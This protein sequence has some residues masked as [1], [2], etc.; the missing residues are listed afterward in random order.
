MCF[1]FPIP[2]LWRMCSAAF[3]SMGGTGFTAK[4]KSNPFASDAPNAAACSS[5]S[6]L[7]L[8]FG[9]GFLCGIGAGAGQSKMAIERV[10]P[11]HSPHVAICASLPSTCSDPFRTLRACAHELNQL[12]RTGIDTTGPHSTAHQPSEHLPSPSVS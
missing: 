10:T 12:K 1:N 4:P 7:L 2:C 8:A 6:A 11:I 9:R 3:A 5:A